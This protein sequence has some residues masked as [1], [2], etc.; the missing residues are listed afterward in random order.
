MCVWC[1]TNLPH[2]TTETMRR[3]SL[4]E[5]ERCLGHRLTLSDKELHAVAYG[6][7]TEIEEQDLEKVRIWPKHFDIC[8]TQLLL[9]S[10]YD[11]F[12]I[13]SC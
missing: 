8:L 6:S 3:S 1:S 2:K 4:L 12:I 7:D 13:I 11:C 10:D 5:L 9:V